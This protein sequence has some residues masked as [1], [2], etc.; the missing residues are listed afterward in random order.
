M[1]ISFRMIF[2]EGQR[3]PWECAKKWI[4]D[5][6]SKFATTVMRPNTSMS[7]LDI[8]VSDLASR[9]RSQVYGNIMFGHYKNLE[10]A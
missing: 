6:H 4:L 8:S 7:F 3:R 5:C 10:A 9:S 2:G 1:K